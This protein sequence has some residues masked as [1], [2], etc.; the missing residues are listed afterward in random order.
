MSIKTDT[1]TTVLV[2]EKD[3][4]MLA[5]LKIQSVILFEIHRYMAEKGMIQ[6]MPVILSKFT[7]PLG[8]D[9]GSSVIKTGEIEYQGQKLQLTQSMILH[10]QIA[11]GK[12]LEKFYIMSPNIRLE[13]A[14]RKDSGVHAFEFTQVDFE[15]AGETSEFVYKFTEDLMRRVR[16]AVVELAGDELRKLDRK[17][18]QWEDKFPRYTSHELIDKYGEDWERLSS[19][20]EKTPYWVICHKR[21]FYDKLDRSREGEH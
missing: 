10:K 15:F 8:P 2:Y 9:P 6:L 5:R 14:H 19:L 20:E 11:I 18:T 1:T 16:D 4:D 17:L 13:S 12:G 3:E 21:E 7:D